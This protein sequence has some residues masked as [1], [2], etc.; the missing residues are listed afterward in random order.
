MIT[1]QD[2]V[3]RNPSKEARDIMM[4]ALRKSCEDQ[5]KLLQKA[6]EITMEETLKAINA[7]L[8][9]IDITLGKIAAALENK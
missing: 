5:N 7:A 1:I 2:L 3:S 8:V 9:N 4:E 6:K